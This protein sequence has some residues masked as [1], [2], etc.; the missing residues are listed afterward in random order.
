MVVFGY[1]QL[2]DSP[3]YIAAAEELL[4]GQ[5]TPSVNC[6]TAPGYPILLMLTKWLTGYNKYII[7]ILQSIFFVASLAY[8]SKSIQERYQF[9]PKLMLL[10]MLAVVISP[11]II[12]LNISTMT[13]SIVTSFLLIIVGFTFLEKRTQ[14]DYIYFIIATC[15]ISLTKFEYVLFIIPTFILLLKQSEYKV[16]LVFISILGSSLVLNGLKNQQ[17]YGT[18][19]PTSFGAG[20][21][22][23]G[24]NNLNLNGSWQIHHKTQDYV[25]Q[26]YNSIFDSLNNTCSACACVG[27][28][29]VYLDMAIEAWQANYMDQLKVIPLK[30]GK[31]WLLPGSMDFYTGQS[32][33]FHGLQLPLLF[34]DNKWPW[35]G[36]YKHGLYLLVYWAYLLLSIIGLFIR[37]RTNG[38]DGMDKLFLFFLLLNSVL[39]SIPFYGLGRFH[40]PVIIFLFYYLTFVMKA[41]FAKQ[42]DKA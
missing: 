19:K 6:N 22:I 27:R 15:L 7:A 8:F 1:E 17:I 35:Y 29:E 32:K 30:F 38:F 9:N 23:Y 37:Y 28:N 24:G 42:L 33:I 20:T 26:R 16:V 2:G 39:Y 34:D 36:K 4:A 3:R 11:E 12:H 18:F 25:P 5:F 21:V 13:E 31:Q 10:L 40:L 41:I 14:K